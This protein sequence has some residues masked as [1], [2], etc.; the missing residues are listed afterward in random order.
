MIDNLRGTDHFRLWEVAGTAHADAHRR[1]SAKDIDCGVPINNGPMHIVAKAALRALTTWLTTGKA[2]VIAPVHRCHSGQDAGD[3]AQR[4]RHRARR[5]PYTAR[6]RAGRGALGRTRAEPV[7]DLPACSARRSRSPS[8]RASRS[9]IPSRA[10]L[11]AAATTRGDRR[12]DQ[13]RLRRSPKTAPVRPAFVEPSLIAGSFRPAV[14]CRN[15]ACFEPS[16]VSFGCKSC[17]RLLVTS[18]PLRE[19]HATGDDRLRTA[20]ESM[21][22]AEWQSSAAELTEVVLDEEATRLALQARG[23]ERP[24]RRGFPT[25]AG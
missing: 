6:R 11:H 3:P 1:P 22:N 2:P 17:S 12:H 14:H 5:Y 18:V 7:D 4:R 23:R 10:V 15:C 25:T 8:A 16:R 9:S 21:T 20:G 24:R 19:S 13:G